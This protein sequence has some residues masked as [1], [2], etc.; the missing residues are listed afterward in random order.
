MGS[1]GDSDGSKSKNWQTGRLAAT[2]TSKKYPGQPRD[3]A[4]IM[5]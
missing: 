1:R 2:E 5:P 4:V 3:H